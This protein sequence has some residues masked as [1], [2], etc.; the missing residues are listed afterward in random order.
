MLNNDNGFGFTEQI[1][2]KLSNKMFREL[3]AYKFYKTFVISTEFSW[4]LQNIFTAIVIFTNLR[5]SY[6]INSMNGS[7]WKLSDIS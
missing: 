1:L 5:K 6:L 4:I 7:R 3:S 2:W